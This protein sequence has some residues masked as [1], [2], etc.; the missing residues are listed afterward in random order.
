[1]LINLSEKNSLLKTYV[2][3]LRDVQVH[4]DRQRF[5]QNMKRIGEII[6]Y[7]ISKQFA[8]TPRTIQTPLDKADGFYLAEQPILVTILRAGMALHDGLLSYFDKADSAFISAYR[9]HDHIGNFNIRL[10]YVSCPPI[11]DRI[12]IISDPMLATGA[13]IVA[14]V[15]EL[16]KL[17]MPQQIYIATAIAREPG[18]NYVLTE[19]D[20]VTI[21]AAAVDPKL[22]NKAYIVPGL[23]DAG[24]LAYGEKMQG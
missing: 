8:Y 20:D 6:A 24:D 16:Q 3:E 17:G 13:S 1:M 7:E 2:T 15:R 5:R 14:T 23:G 22:N 10:E 21:Y 9:E 19:L 4:T 12:L 11:K 18:I